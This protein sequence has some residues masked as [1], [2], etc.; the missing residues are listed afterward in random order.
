MDIQ[1]AA[2]R[3]A[4]PAGPP[5]LRHTIGAMH[6][7]RVEALKRQ[8]AA[9]LAAGRTLAVRGAGT[10]GI[11]PPPEQLPE[12][13]EIS[14]LS[15]VIDWQPDE[16]VVSVA[17]GT[18]LAELEAILAGQRQR[19]L[20]EPWLPMASST[21]GGAVATGFS[22]PGRPWLGS[23][24]DGVLG[25]RL[26]TAP[27]GRLVDGRFGG[28]VIKNVAGFDVS[29]LQVGACGIFGALLEINLRLAPLPASSRW[30]RAEMGPEEGFRRLLELEPPEWP[31]TGAALAGDHLH[32][33]LE[34]EPSVVEAAIRTL[35]PDFSEAAPDFW[36]ALRA[37]HLPLASRLVGGISQAGI[38]AASDSPA[39]A[40]P[41]LDGHPAR[42]ADPAAVGGHWR[43]FVPR[44]TPPLALPGAWV[45]DW[46]G[47]LQWWRT[48]EDLPYATVLAVAR[49]AG[50]RA[51]PVAA[52]P[53]VWLPEDEI[54]P[55]RALARELDPAGLFNIGLLGLPHSER[56]G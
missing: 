42:G 45:I 19:L 54:K 35:G 1:V 3:V 31:V 10:R 16:L 56:P 38:R 23:V 5:G 44:G 47:A 18:P 43:I 25:V 21:V 33:R 37:G 12:P 48:P 11:C 8:A 28:R 20:G 29:R 22:G 26:L 30:L 53:F 27:G 6:E 7:T 4:V 55:H 34:G 9:A 39:P 14:A 41:T 17:A 24:S 2:A 13:L 49:A 36:Q 50:G 51:L 40:H 32:L 46:G 15:G 52:P